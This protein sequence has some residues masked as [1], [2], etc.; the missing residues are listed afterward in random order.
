MNDKEILKILDKY[1][2]VCL[3]LNGH[4]HKGD[5]KL[6]GKRHH[7]NLRGMQNFADSWYQLDFYQDKIKVFQAEKTSTPVYELSIDQSWKK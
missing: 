5:Y 1:P 2:N 6:M 4:N 3:Y 7:L